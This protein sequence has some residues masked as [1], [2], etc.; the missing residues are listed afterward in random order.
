MEEQLLRKMIKEICREEGIACRALCQGWVMRLKKGAVCRFVTGNNFD[1]NTEASARIASDKAA[2]YEALRAMKVPAVEHALALNPATRAAFMPPE[3]LWRQ[4]ERFFEEHNHEIVVKPN[5]GLQG[6]GCSLCR[7]MADV[8]RA[9]HALF[10]DED[11]AALSPFVP[12]AREYRVFSLN[13]RPEYAYA[14]RKPYVTGNGHDTAMKLIEDRFAG[15]EPKKLVDFLNFTDRFRVPADGETVELSWKFNLSGGALVE[16]ELPA[17]IR[18]R[19]Y[20]L[21]VKAAR[22]VNLRFGTVDILD[23]PEGLKVLEVNSGIGLTKFV[24]QADGGYGII[25]EIVR[26]AIQTM[27]D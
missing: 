8:Q 20:A 15:I 11:A 22:A 25:K 27:F 16:T 5:S 3:G 9:V 19:V 13:G 24:G 14:K 12:S 17:G 4:A 2:T 1:L 18:K 23:T 7:T 6:R 26:K 21:A 10:R